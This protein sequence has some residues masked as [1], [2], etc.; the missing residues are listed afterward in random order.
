[1][2]IP[3]GRDLFNT[4][5]SIRCISAFPAAYSVKYLS[6]PDA[7][8]VCGD[9]SEDK[10]RHVAAG[11]FKCNVGR[12]MEDPSP[13]TRQIR[14]STRRTG[15]LMI[16]HTQHCKVAEGMW[17]LPFAEGSRSTPFK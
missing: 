6:G 12:T 16:L 9:I 10:E 17:G 5:L 8:Y 4:H 1:M 13:A 11:K 14:S 2:P 7:G 3:S 15:H